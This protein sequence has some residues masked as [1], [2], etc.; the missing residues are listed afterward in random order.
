MN[1]LYIPTKD[2]RLRCGGNEQR[3]NLLW[4]AL[5]KMGNVYTVIPT[6]ENV[7]I[8][9][10]NQCRNPMAYAQ[11]INNKNIW[12][13]LHRILL[14]LTGISILEKK[15]T[16]QL[17]INGIFKNVKFDIVVTRY[18]YSSCHQDFGNIAP[19][20]IDI[21][22]HPYQIFHTTRKQ[23]LP[24]FVRPV[25]KWLLKYQ[26]QHILHKTAGGWIA[27]AEQVSNCGNNYAFL[28]NIPATPS[29][30]YSINEE[31]RDYLLTIGNME[32]TPNYQGVTTFIKEIWPLF[33]DKYPHV[34]YIIGGKGAPESCVNMWNNTDGVTY[35]GFIDDIEDIYQHCLVTVVPVDT[36]GG[37]CIKTLESLAFSRECL[38][39]PFGSRGLHKHAKESKG[40]LHIYNT[41][42]DFVELFKSI[43]DSEIRHNQEK[44]SCDFINRCYSV[45]NFEQ[46]VKT[47]IIECKK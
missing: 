33:H 41:A 1:I 20:F 29:S 32:Y 22:D 39:T 26:V 42:N 12:Y 21:D 25:A 2:P 10:Y 19:T 36:G 17:N 23:R 45:E 18:I 9:D 8:D 13:L 24:F 38:A 11:I 46:C 5:K 47:V 34:K 37:T 30:K 44:Y 7:S 6:S 27:N 40:C 31:C 4:K 43:L 3:T 16:E 14:F 28:P 15:I 35:S